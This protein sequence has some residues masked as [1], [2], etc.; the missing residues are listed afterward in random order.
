M[1]TE[2]TASCAREVV[3]GAFDIDSGTAETHQGNSEGT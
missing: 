1:K 3:S 2:A